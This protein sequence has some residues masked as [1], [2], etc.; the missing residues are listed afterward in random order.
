V[1]NSAIFLSRASAKFKY[2]LVA[3]SKRASLF[4]P[5][6]FFVF[7]NFMNSILTRFFQSDALRQPAIFYSSA[8]AQ[9][10]SIHFIIA[11]HNRW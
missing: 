9:L 6:D 11:S 10:I 4:L 7:C 5:P 2:S 8:K 1:L 3:Y